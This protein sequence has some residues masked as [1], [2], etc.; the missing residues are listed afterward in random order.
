MGLVM[1]DLWTTADVMLCTSSILHMCTISLDRYLGIRNPLKTRNKSTRIVVIKIAAVWIISMAISSP[2]VVLGIIDERNVLNDGICGMAN[3]YFIIYGSIS[4]FFIPLIIMVST[5][6]M[7]VQLL[8]KQAAL[9]SGKDGSVAVRRST[10]RKKGE[11]TNKKTLSW[12]P[13]S[14]RTSLSDSEHS[15]TTSKNGYS[16]IGKTIGSKLKHYNDVQ[17]ALP[18]EVEP[19]HN[20]HGTTVNSKQNNCHRLQRHVGGGGGPTNH[21]AKLSTL[22][23][24]HGFALRT[25]GLLLPKNKDVIKPKETSVQTEQK[26]AKVLAIIFIIFV[27]CWLPFFTVN[28]LT[29]LCKTCV[30]S[31]LLFSIFLWLGYVSSTINPIIYTIF[32]K[33]FRRM[34]IK[35]ILCQYCEKRKIHKSA[36]F[37]NAN[38]N[39]VKIRGS[40]SDEVCVTILEETVL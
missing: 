33:T 19:L 10:S 35:I 8:R 17:D 7:T 27:L 11:E 20:A 15:P 21:A 12:G 16:K 6:M 3:F 13:G 31:D 14:R 39:S 37:P 26:A 38:G 18:D 36:T 5:N 40:T 24:K 22:V 4:A 25:A 34:F 2:T 9:C 32:N 30:I 1:C 23:Q 28:V 29:A